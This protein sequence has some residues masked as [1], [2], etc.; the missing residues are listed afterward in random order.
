MGSKARFGVRRRVSLR[1]RRISSGCLQP[2]RSSG[3]RQPNR[4]LP[5]APQ[6]PGRVA[7]VTGA[8]SGIGEAIACAFG[9]EGAHVVLGGRRVSELE[10]VTSVITRAGG[11]A[12]AVPGDVRREADVLELFAAAQ[13]TYGR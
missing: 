1:S 7:I 6:M 9:A 8:S 12:I 4:S 5:N 10:R 11:S 2:T 13:R 3:G